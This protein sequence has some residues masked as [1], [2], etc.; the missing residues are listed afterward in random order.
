M[1]ATDFNGRRIAE[2]SSVAL[3]RL[4]WDGPQGTVQEIQDGRCWVTFPDA[5]K[6]NGWYLGR[7]LV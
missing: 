6:L 2:G 5:E 4:P 7:H 1:F 3:V